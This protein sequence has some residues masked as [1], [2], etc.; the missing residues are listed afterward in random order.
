MLY[1]KVWDDAI[2]VFKE[3]GNVSVIPTPQF[4]YPMKQ[5]EE[6]IIE[7]TAGKTIIVKLLSIGSPNEDGLRTVFFKINGQNRFVEILDKSLAIYV[8]QSLECDRVIKEAKIHKEGSMVL[9]G[10]NDATPIIYTDEADTKS[11]QETEAEKS[12]Q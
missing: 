1:P 4:F 9:L 5:N 2:K 10:S 8:K 3:Y 11:L 12:L 6:V 7:I